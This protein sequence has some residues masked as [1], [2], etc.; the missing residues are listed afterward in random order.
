MTNLPIFLF[1]H[2]FP[3]P[4]RISV[5]TGHE[6]LRN[7][8]TERYL[9]TEML[10]GCYGAD[11]GVRQ[12][13]AVKDVTVKKHRLSLNSLNILI[14]S[15]NLSIFRYF[16]IFLQKEFKE[17]NQSP[18]NLIKNNHEKGNSMEY[19]VYYTINSV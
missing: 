9:C 19:I 11:T 3:Y 12:C 10:R 17:Q 6:Q 14:Y 5:A 16:L 8:S 4:H 7:I 18:V 13:R 2:K 15:Q 1:Q